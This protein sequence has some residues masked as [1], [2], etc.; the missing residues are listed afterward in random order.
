[1]AELPRDVKWLE[2]ARERRRRVA[3]AVRNGRA[4]EDP[5]DAPYAVG[6]ADASL[7]WLS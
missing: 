4:V 2:L 1:M 7:D 3:R 5:R 6:F